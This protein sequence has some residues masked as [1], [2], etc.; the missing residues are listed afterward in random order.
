MNIKHYILH[1]LLSLLIG[2][3][4]A[5]ASS[6]AT[7]YVYNI[8]IKKLR[9]AGKAPFGYLKEA[10][11]PEYPNVMDFY[12]HMTPPPG[13][14]YKT[15]G[16]KPSSHTYQI[17]HRDS[18]N[19]G[20]KV[21]VIN[22][23]FF[24]VRDGSFYVRLPSGSSRTARVWYQLW[25]LNFEGIIRDTNIKLLC[26]TPQA[27]FLSY[28][29]PST[30][31]SAVV[32]YAGDNGNNSWTKLDPQPGDVTLELTPAIEAFGFVTLHPTTITQI[33]KKEQIGTAIVH[34]PTSRVEITLTGMQGPDT[35]RTFVDNGEEFQLGKTIMVYDFQGEVKLW[36]Q[37]DAAAP[38]RRTNMLRYS[39]TFA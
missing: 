20:E 36:A 39:V 21:G 2:M 13:C 24:D 6:Q 16:L 14:R 22:G 12:Y 26:A 37:V 27:T 8:A 9:I 31:M 25:E 29:V 11:W 19:T 4:T 7:D 5:N 3:S 28:V 30:G 34:P 18:W 33:G 35:I 32:A 38:G 17:I 15:T 1:V 23:E 10:K